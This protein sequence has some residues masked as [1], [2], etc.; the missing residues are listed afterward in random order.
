MIVKNPKIIILDE[1]TSALDID[2]EKKVLQN[3]QTV[4][5]NKTIF[6]ITHRLS[7]LI[8]ADN[9]FLM[10]EGTIIE[11]GTHAELIKKDSNYSL[12]YKQ[13]MN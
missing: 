13:Q 6:F 10:H 2:T 8:K 7:N 11:Q 12:L 5:K 9:I 1:A 3:I 4:F